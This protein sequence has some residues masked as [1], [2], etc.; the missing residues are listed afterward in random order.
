M[1]LILALQYC[2]VNIFQTLLQANR[3][4]KPVCGLIAGVGD[5]HAV[6][7]SK[8]HRVLPCMSV[9]AIVCMFSGIA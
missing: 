8:H 2:A 6:I 3:R 5:A 1:H 4:I 7:S 9:H